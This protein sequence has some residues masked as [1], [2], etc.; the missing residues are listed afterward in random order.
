MPTTNAMLRRTYLGRQD[1]DP[2]EADLE[3]GEIWFDTDT[4][5]YRGY[6]GTNYGDIGFTEDA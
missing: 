5:T 2:D 1:G 6:D 4:N 3:G